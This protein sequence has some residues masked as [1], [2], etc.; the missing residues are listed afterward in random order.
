MDSSTEVQAWRL[1]RPEFAPGLD[2]MGARRVGGR[3]NSPGTG[4]VYCAGS[5][6]LAA[7][8][9]FVHIPPS[10][11]SP[12]K[13]PPLV[14]VSLTL[15]ADEPIEHLAP[16]DFAAMV[17]LADFQSCGDAW[18]ASG[19]SLALRVPSLVIPA[20]RNLLLNP[21]HPGMARVRVLDQLPFVWDRR[22]GA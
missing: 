5:L 14:A 22:M 13:L 4:M 12:D 7:L 15:A 8:E 17:T 6:A 3:W 18:V 21:A 1:V 2:G 16:A 19:R 9:Y 20:E 11:R 10:M